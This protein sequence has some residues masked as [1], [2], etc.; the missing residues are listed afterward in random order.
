MPRPDRDDAP[1]DASR[2]PSLDARSALAAVPLFQDLPDD[3][4]ARLAGRARRLSCDAEQV[5]F[6]E[7]DVAEGLYVVAAGWLKVTKISAAGRE[8]VLRDVGPGDVLQEIGLLLETPNPASLVALE[9]ATLWL[10]PRAAVLRVTQETPSLLWPLL[11]NLARRLLATVDLVE[12]LS[13]RTLEARL[14][15]YLLDRADEDVF[16]RRKW[17]TQA[18][19]AARLGTVPDVLHRVLRGLVEDGL[20]RVERQRVLLLDREGLE[21]KARLA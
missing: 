10:L 5:V 7:G 2:L 21:A 17:A 4:L 9:P 16:E 12:S 14:A 6:L 19:L 11:Q 20:I 8:Q 3:V 1:R 15:R 18:E 13:L